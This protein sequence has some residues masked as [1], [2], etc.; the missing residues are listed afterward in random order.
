MNIL[1]LVYHLLSKDVDNIDCQNVIAARGKV[2]PEF[3]RCGIRTNIIDVYIKR[4]AK[5][6]GKD[7]LA[8]IIVII[9]L[10][11]IAE[12]QSDTALV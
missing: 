9:K 6:I 11:R 8:T 1:E 3:I 7:I 5:V 2:D 12:C 4:I 10:S